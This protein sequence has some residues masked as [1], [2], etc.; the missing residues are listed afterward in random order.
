MEKTLQ[1]KMVE[2]IEA[3]RQAWL[4]LTVPGAATM[5]TPEG[6]ALVERWIAARDA[7]DTAVDAANAAAARAADLT[8]PRD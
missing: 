3:S 7:A 2:A 4:A 5:A 6:R 1:Q 8:D